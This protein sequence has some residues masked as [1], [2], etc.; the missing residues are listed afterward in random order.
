VNY[1]SG[2]GVPNVYRHQSKWLLL[3]IYCHLGNGFTVMSPKDLS[4]SPCCLFCMFADDLKL[5]C[6]ILFFSPKELQKDINVVLEWSKYLL[7]S[8]DVEKCEVVH[9][10]SALKVYNHKWN[11]TGTFIDSYTKL[12]FLIQIQ[13][14]KACHILG[15]FSKLFEYKEYGVIV[16][17]AI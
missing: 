3:N 7:L 14:P 2:S 6:V 8:F 15:P 11:S 16:T 17:L 4:L 12:K 13:L 10:G 1:W 5:Y 9:I